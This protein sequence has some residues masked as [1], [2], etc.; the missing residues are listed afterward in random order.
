MGSFDRDKAKRE[1]KTF[2]KEDLLALYNR[3]DDSTDCLSHSKVHFS[4]EIITMILYIYHNSRKDRNQRP[5]LTVGQIIDRDEFEAA[6]VRIAIRAIIDNIIDKIKKPV[7]LY[8]LFTVVEKRTK[9]EKEAKQ[10]QKAEEE[11]L[12]LSELM[13]N[14]IIFQS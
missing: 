8:N 4:E 3:I 1:G 10:A 2:G 12:N 13:S 11:R 9:A 7:G 14:G 6:S 5:R